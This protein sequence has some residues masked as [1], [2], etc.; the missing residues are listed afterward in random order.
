MTNNRNALCPCGSGLKYKKCHL[1]TLGNPYKA[2]SKIILKTQQVEHPYSRYKAFCQVNSTKNTINTLIAMQLDKRNHG[3]NIRIETLLEIAIAFTNSAHDWSK[4]DFE[5]IINLEFANNHLE[6]LPEELFTSNILTGSGNKV[7]Y[8]GIATRADKIL[9]ILLTVATNFK[10]NLSTDISQTIIRVVDLFS[11]LVSMT[12]NGAET[13]RNTY[14]D[15]ESKALLITFLPSDCGIS[16]ATIINLFKKYHLNPKLIYNFLAVHTDFRKNEFNPD[17]N[18]ILQKPIITVDGKFYLA[19]I[20]NETFALNWFIFHAAIKTKND[21][22]LLSAYSDVVWNQIEN[23]IT[24]MGWVKLQTP[25]LPELPSFIRCIIC[26]FDFDK[27]ALIVLALPASL[28]TFEDTMNRD[29]LRKQ[30]KETIDFIEAAV[31]SLQLALPQNEVFVLHLF[32]TL[33]ITTEIECAEN[34]NETLGLSFDVLNFIALGKNEN[35]SLLS[36]YNYA[37]AKK[38]LHQYSQVPLQ[39][40]VALYG[41]YKSRNE[42]FYLTDEK[43]PNKVILVPGTGYSLIRA[44]V[45]ENDEHG[46]W[47]YLDGGGGYMQVKRHKIF[48]RLYSYISD[49]NQCEHVYPNHGIPIWFKCIN[50]INQSFGNIIAEAVAFWSSKVF[51]N[52]QDLFKAYIYKSMHVEI[53]LRELHTEWSYETIDSYRVS[54]NIGVEFLENLSNDP[55]NGLEKKLVAFVCRCIFQVSGADSKDETRKWVEEFIDDDTKRIILAMNPHADVRLSDIDLRPKFHMSDAS[56]NFL[57][58][59]LGKII[60]FKEYNQ[61]DF[62][63]DNEKIK[64]VNILVG[65]LLEHLKFE[66]AKLDKVNLLSFLFNINERLIYDAEKRRISHSLNQLT[67]AS[68]LE[69]LGKYETDLRNNIKTARATRCLIE[70]IVTEDLK[71]NGKVTF[72]KIEELMAIMDQI[73]AMGLLSDTIKFGLSSPA[74]KILPSGRLGVGKEFAEE[75]LYPFYTEKNEDEWYYRRSSIQSK[76]NSLTTFPKLEKVKESTE[77]KPDLLIELDKAFTKDFQIELS[78][79]IRFLK[80]AQYY[81]LDLNKSVVQETVTN[82]ITTISEKHKIAKNELLKAFEFLCLIGPA[83]YLP[84]SDPYKNLDVYPWRY[85]RELSIL[86]RPFLKFNR[87][88]QTFVLYGLRAT[89][90]AL[91]QIFTMIEGCSFPYAKEGLTNYFGSKA[92]QKGELFRAEALNWLKINPNLRVVDHEVP[93]KPGKLFSSNTNL[94]DIDILAYDIIGNKI[95]MI[96]CKDTKVPRNVYEIHKEVLAYYGSS[97]KAGLLKK[98]QARYEWALK[99]VGIITT[100]LSAPNDAKIVSIIL[101]SDTLALKFIKK[102]HASMPILSLT[103]LKRLGV[104]RLLEL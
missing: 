81:A 5:S 41:V 14:Y 92:N 102:K 99:N 36:L 6:D 65:K 66:I 64:F 38:E 78:S 94:G 3:K 89:E 59:N 72:S 7:I 96:E 58:N 30:N 40:L 71:S 25:A 52:R 88:G 18:P 46:E 100:F 83:S 4:A 32:D 63:D 68:D 49:K 86:R 70:L 31:K 55:T 82:W 84:P 13:A 44:S 37:K 93:I 16:E 17:R 51:E 48:K 10:K 60:Q 101:S 35:W 50:D 87:N 23:V 98:Q 97:G 20:T 24:S 67:F 53:N 75:V 33:L 43:R 77:N 29:C 62:S 27:I 69:G 11:E 21:K 2:V 15:D 56:T 79:L 45:Q 9:Q 22:N 19:G 42:S 91:N 12:A 54:I 103:E 85:S 95:F 8:N 61:M 73:I 47:F 104:S 1:D 57:L 39:D 26:K 28:Y 90:Q 80:I 76:L 34:M 74:L